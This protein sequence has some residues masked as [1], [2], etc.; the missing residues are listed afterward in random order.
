MT[1]LAG[2][3]RRTTPSSARSRQRTMR[4]REQRH[5]GGVFTDTSLP[6][7]SRCRLIWS[8]P[9]RMPWCDSAITAS[10][11]CSD[12]MLAWSFH[13]DRRLPSGNTPSSGPTRLRMP[14]ETERPMFQTIDVVDDG[15]PGILQLEAFVTT[16][17]GDA[18]TAFA[19]AEDTC[20][21]VTLTF[22]TFS[23]YG[24]AVPGQQIRLYTAWTSA[25]TA[26]RASSWCPSRMR[27]TVPAAPTRRHRTTMRQQC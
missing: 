14:A 24:S 20:S 27:P 23:A 11:N 2:S 26:P 3:C 10:D 13:G 17:C 21:A 6:T 22:A 12:L 18:L 7:S 8:S 4:Q 1:T 9:A 25:A 5:P 16:S 19:S 15:G